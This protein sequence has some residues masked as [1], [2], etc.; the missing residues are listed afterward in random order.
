LYK[1]RNIAVIIPALNEESSVGKVVAE[2]PDYVDRT[3]VCD[4]GSTD[5]T[6]D[7]AKSAGAEVVFEP[8]RGYG[9]A[10]LRA[11]E[12]LN[13]ST[14]II[15]F[16]DA[17]Y[18]DYPEEMPLLLNP[19][20]DDNHEV[21]IGSRMLKA[22]SRKILTPVS[23]FGNW[24]S[25]SLIRLFWGYHFTDLGPFR[26]I[27]FPAYQRLNMS[28]QNYGWTVELQVKAARQQMKATEVPVSYRSRIG[29]SKISGTIMGSV[30]AGI[31]ILYFIFRELLSR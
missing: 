22:E 26:A 1:N 3:I 13:N 5:K 20:T 27:T 8:K 15:V 30:K 21:V 11:I 6:A 4:N 2:I 19:I 12:Q 17:D 14:D 31:T 28:D 25:T 29:S 23:R 18:S 10:C 24:L 7:M 16:M 9:A